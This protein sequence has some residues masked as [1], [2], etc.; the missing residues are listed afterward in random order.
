MSAYPGVRSETKVTCNAATLDELCLN[1]IL[2]KKLHKIRGRKKCVRIIFRHDQPKLPHLPSLLFHLTIDFFHNRV[3][4]I[5]SQR[6]FH[7]LEYHTKSIR[8]FSIFF[9]GVE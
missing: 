7:R 6:L 2:E 9:E 5:I 8:D 3:R 4:L 1:Y